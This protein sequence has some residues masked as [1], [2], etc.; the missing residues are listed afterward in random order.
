MREKLKL[1][2]VFVNICANL[3]NH[4]DVVVL[5]IRSYKEK[6]KERKRWVVIYGSEKYICT[7]K[8]GKCTPMKLVI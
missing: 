6:K 8:S 3:M 7:L 5:G 2:E 1:Y 4:I